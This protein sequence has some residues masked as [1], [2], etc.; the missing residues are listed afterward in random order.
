MTN[1]LTLENWLGH[2]SHSNN[3]PECWGLVLQSEL[4]FLLDAGGVGKDIHRYLLRAILE[5]MD[6]FLAMLTPNSHHVVIGLVGEL[7]EMVAQGRYR[8]RAVRQRVIWT[9]S[10]PSWRGA[11]FC[12]RTAP[13]AGVA[14]KSVPLFIAAAI[15]DGITWGKIDLDKLLLEVVSDLGMNVEDMERSL[16]NW[17]K[18]DAY[19]ELRQS[20]MAKADFHWSN[21][22]ETAPEHM[23]LLLGKYLYSSLEDAEAR[24]D[25]IDAT[26]TSRDAERSRS[27]EERLKEAFAKID[28]LF[29]LPRD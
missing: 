5:D 13:L 1:S 4:A 15:W 11:F 3:D 9:E 6:C 19:I 16:N 17:R 18:K 26:L 7:S 27:Q 10:E 12:A 23:Q 22:V 8:N 25:L 29:P 24:M 2:Y 28:A 21:L 20:F 14:A